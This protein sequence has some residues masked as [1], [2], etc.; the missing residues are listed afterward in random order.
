MNI[1]YPLTIYFD[2][3]CR[4][5]NSEMQNIKLHDTDNQLVLIDCSAADFDTTICQD[6]NISLTE[7][8]NRLHAQDAK[9]L[10]I[11][12]VPAFELIYQTVGMATIAKLWGHPWAERLYPW[13]VQHRYLLSSI[14]L[15]ALITLW[16][17]Y[18]ARKAEQRS[19]LCRE[20]K[21]TIDE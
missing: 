3:S 5:C 1:T 9:G 2:A 16:G 15:P 12:G 4:L 6:H 8:M 13:V 20:G 7:M 11:I 21:C 17:R 10:W 14:G 19:R 18:A